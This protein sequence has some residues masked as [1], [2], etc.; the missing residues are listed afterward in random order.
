MTISTL[1]N[2]LQAI[3]RKHGDLRV[4]CIDLGNWIKTVGSVRVGRSPVDGKKQVIID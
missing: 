1:I 3:K 4:K 2:R